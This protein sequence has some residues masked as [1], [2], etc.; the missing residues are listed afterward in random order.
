MFTDEKKYKIVKYKVTYE[1][2]EDDCGI[3]DENKDFYKKDLQRIK[4][5]G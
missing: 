3:E 1:I 5:R 2:I 4:E